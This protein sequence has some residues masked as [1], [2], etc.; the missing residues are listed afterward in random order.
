MSVKSL[1]VAEWCNRMVIEPIAHWWK[2]A[3]FA[4]LRPGYRW[5]LSQKNHQ[6]RTVRP[7]TQ[8]TRSSTHLSVKRRAVFFRSL[9]AFRV[10][11]YYGR[12]NKEKVNDYRRWNLKLKLKRGP[13]THL[14]LPIIT[15]GAAKDNKMKIFQII[16]LRKGDRGDIKAG[17]CKWYSK[18]HRPHEICGSKSLVTQGQLVGVVG[19]LL[20]LALIHN[21]SF[22]FHCTVPFTRPWRFVLRVVE[23]FIQ[24]GKLANCHL[25]S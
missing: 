23:N 8:Q 20:K 4:V 13:K 17:S 1:S 7:L 18:I 2:P 21:S 19:K 9:L 25:G 10:N 15:I 12:T 16:T 22:L 5:W 6:R 3:A 11:G 14:Q 24:A